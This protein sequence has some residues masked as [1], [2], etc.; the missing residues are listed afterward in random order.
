MS[1]L[2]ADEW[3]LNGERLLGGAMNRVESIEQPHLYGR[4]NVASIGPDQRF[5]F[6]QAI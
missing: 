5:F 4:S 2:Q 3:R 1:P 6:E